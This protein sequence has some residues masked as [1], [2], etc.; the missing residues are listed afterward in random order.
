MSDLILQDKPRKIDI[1]VP[2]IPS[3]WKITQGMTEDFIHNPALACKVLL[4]KDQD[5]YQSSRMKLSWW[6]PRF[7]DSSGFSSAKTIGLF[8]LACLRAMIMEDHHIGVY[9]QIF[10]TGQQTFWS[11][12]GPAMMRSPYFR[13][14]MGKMDINGEDGDGTGSERKGP[15]C[16]VAN[17]RNGSKILMPAPS[18]LQDAKTQASIRLND[19]F[20]DEWTKIEATGS[21]GIDDQLIGRATRAC[22]NQE[23]P[24]WCNKQGFLAT[25][26][27]ASHPA[28]KRYQEFLEEVKLGNPDYVLLNYSY[29]DYSPEFRQYRE[30][31]VLKDL[32]K[33]KTEQGF[34]QEGLG[35]WGKTGRKWYSQDMIDAA[36]EKGRYRRVMPLTSR[37]EDT[38]PDQPKVFF[39]E[40]IDP[41]KADDKKADD[42]AKVILRAKQRT[43]EVSQDVT[44]WQLDWS[45]AYKVRKADAQQW[46]SII[47]K[48][49]VAFNLAGIMMDSQGGGNWI[50]PELGKVK[51]NVA[52]KDEKHTP[53]ACIED[54]GDIMIHARFILS[55]FKIKDR[56][57]DKLFGHMKLSSPDNLVDAAH[58]EFFEAWEKGYFG[59]PP[60]LSELTEEQ[61]KGWSQERIWA[62]TLLEVM[63]QQLTRV[64]VETE[65]DG[66]IMLTKNGARKFKVLR[67]RKDFAYA[68]MYA[69][70]RFL[71]WLKGLEQDGEVPEEDRDMCA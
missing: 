37:D 49:D 71:C 45:Y 18:F 28:F 29:K 57:V 20:I 1:Y 61:M 30:N 22:Y 40:G 44:D 16:W 48:K 15:S 32:R 66:T 34:I 23:H 6:S 41:S 11:Y 25:A 36:R 27:D 46:A 68:A 43:K 33:R 31:R 55:M 67:G 13:H 4:A 47:H 26:E 64:T 59:L 21:T 2:S 42:G 14:Y 52:G 58:S 9:Y 53:I 7:M 39:F 19:L 24:F 10:S 17:F 69:Y 12:F 65:P 3:H 62:C 35:F 38:D 56:R 60:K 51:L 63:A 70:L 5:V 54:S 8:D 50:R